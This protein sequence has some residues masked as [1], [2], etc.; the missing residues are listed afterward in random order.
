MFLTLT[1]YWCW[2][3]VFILYCTAHTT[4]RKTSRPKKALNVKNN[5]L[6]PIITKEYQSS[7]PKIKL[8]LTY[9]LYLLGKLRCI[10]YRAIVDTVLFDNLFFDA[11]CFRHFILFSKLSQHQYT[12]IPVY[13]I[14]CNNFPIPF[15]TIEG[16]NGL[17]N[18]IWE[19]YST[20]HI[21]AW[22]SADVSKYTVLMY[23]RVMGTKT[24]LFSFW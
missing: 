6:K 14:V 5:G 4:C 18:H 23:C 1:R 17:E 3:S 11:S 15:E 22:Y 7:I 12:C 2:V 20:V 21:A 16:K 10:S 13:C 24:K 9:F 19:C 8:I